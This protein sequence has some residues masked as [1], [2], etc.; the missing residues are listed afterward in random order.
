MDWPALLKTICLCLI[1]IIIEAFSASKAGKKWFE[2]LIQP[3]Y[4]FS[5]SL[6]YI[7]GGV[8]YII[9]GIISYRLFHTQSDIF[10]L[11]V[12]LLALIM[13][14]NGLGN[15]IL[16]KFRSLKWFYLVVYPFALLLAVL[17]AVL[18]QADKFS[19]MLASVYLAWLVYDLYYLRNLW[20]LN[21]RSI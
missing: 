3:K 17:V 13:I 10:T 21:Y 8:Y 5:L 9:C 11:P 18:F 7:V 15:F 14:F 12:I 20:K 16:F 6:W 4:S 19:A 1:S 2:K